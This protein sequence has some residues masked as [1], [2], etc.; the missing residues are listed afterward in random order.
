MTV[1][2][3]HPPVTLYLPL[4]VS[5]E[6]L[7]QAREALKDYHWAAQG[8]VAFLHNAEATFLSPSGGF[9]DCTEELTHTQQALASFQEGIQAHVSHLL[10]VVPQ[11]A[12]RVLSFPPTELLHARVLSHVL[13]GRATLEAQAQ[14]RL[15]ALKR[16]GSRSQLMFSLRVAIY[17]YVSL[18]LSFNHMN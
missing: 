17:P 3:D 16:W 6:N 13:V 2:V 12:S 5:Q 9:L 1:L 14:L 8:A 18:P 11:Q 10:D 7:S 4:C 15:E